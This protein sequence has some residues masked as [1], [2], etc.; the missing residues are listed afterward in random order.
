MVVV[1]GVLIIINSLVIV[2]TQQLEHRLLLKQVLSMVIKISTV[3][4]SRST[5]IWINSW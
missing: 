2:E 1:V 5:N 3:Y 4:M